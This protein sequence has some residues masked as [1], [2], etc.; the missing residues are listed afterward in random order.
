MSVS[1]H[2]CVCACPYVCVSVC[3][4]SLFYSVYT[5]CMCSSDSG[6][7]VRNV[8]VRRSIHSAFVSI[9]VCVR[10]REFTAMRC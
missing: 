6:S 3:A 2:M 7:E 4:S 8:R 5:V 10:V 9:H 1:V